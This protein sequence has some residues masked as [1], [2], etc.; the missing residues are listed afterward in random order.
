MATEQDT[1]VGDEWIVP[2]QEY[3]KF[4]IHK[5]GI[6]RI[7]FSSLI[8][9]GIP[10][11][12][13]IGENIRIF[14]LGKEIPVYVST[15]AL[16]TSTDFIEF[17]GHK[18]RGELDR[19]LYLHPDEDMLN[20]NASCFTDT[21][22]YFLTFSTEFEPK[23]AVS[24]FDPELHPVNPYHL[25][26]KSLVFA[27]NQNDPYFALGGGGSVSYSSFQHSEGFARFNE[28]SSITYIFTPGASS[29]GPDPLLHVKFAG[30]NYGNHRYIVSVNDVTVDTAHV[31]DLDFID[32]VYSFP[33]SSLVYQNTFYGTRL[34]TQSRH[35]LV[36]L[37]ITYPHTPDYT[38]STLVRLQLQE[39]AQ[40]RSYAIKGLIENGNLPII[41]NYSGS[42]R[43]VVNSFEQ[44]TFYISNSFPNQSLDL[45]IGKS[46]SGIETI[47][48]LEKKV[49]N[50]ILN[51]NPSYIIISHPQLMD[52]GD[53]EEYAN[54]RRSNEG[55]SY[56]VS[57]FS[58]DDL[59]DRFCYGIK[60]H[61]L[62][63]RNL[64]TYAE[65][66][67]SNT[68]MF[69]II[70]RGIEYHRSR[71]ADG[72]WEK[73]FF[74][75][76][77]GRPG[78]D[79]MLMST[80][81]DIM[82]RYPIGRL[83]VIN[84]A[85]IQE[86]LFKVKEHE[87]LST[88]QTL[89]SSR[90]LKNIMHIGGGQDVNEQEGFKTYLQNLG[91]ILESSSFGGN[92]HFFQKQST[93]NVEQS[94]STEILNLL[95]EGCSLINYFGH[96]GTTTFEYNI[97]D[98]SQWN[99]HGRYSIVSA[100]GCSAGQIYGPA[101]SL[102]D[103]YVH[104]PKEGAI[105]FIS[106]SGNQFSP[107][108][109]TWAK[110]WYQYIGGEG[111]NRSLGEGIQAGL[112]GLLP[113]INIS[114]TNLNQYRFL[115]EQQVLQG[116]PAI[117]LHVAQGPDY[118]PH[119][120]AVTIDEQIINSDLD[121]IDIQ[122]S[123]YNIGRNENDFVPFY[124]SIASA[125]GVDRIV[126]E[127]SV[128]VIGFEKQVKVKVPFLLSENTASF[129]LHIVL[130]PADRIDELPDPAAENNNHLTDDAGVSGLTFFVADNI[131]F[132]VYP[133]TDE[134]VNDPSPLLTASGP[135]ALQGIG[136]YVMEIDTTDLFNSPAFQR[137]SLNTENSS[138]INSI[139]Y[140]WEDDQ[141]YYWRVSPDSI[142]PDKGYKWDRRNFT[143]APGLPGGFDQQRFSQF[144]S[145]SLF[146]LVPNVVSSRFEFA[147]QIRN[148]SILNRYLNITENL[149]PQYVEE[150]TIRNEFFA[151]F[152][153]QKV[154]LFAVVFDSLSG[155]YLM[156]PPGG[157]YGS[158]NH[159]SYEIPCFP[160]R[161]DSALY[162]Q[163]LISFLEDSLPDDSKVLLYCYQRT[164]HPDYFPE[165]WAGD[166]ITFGKDLFTTLESVATGTNI[167]KTE[168]SGSVPF[169]LFYSNNS[170]LIE[171]QIAED[172]TEVL[173]MILNINRP[174]H[175]GEIHSPVIGPALEWGHILHQLSRPSQDDFVQ[176]EAYSYDFTDTLLV[177]S[178]LTTQDTSITDLDASLY[179]YLKLIFKTTDSITYQ[180]SQLSLLRVTFKDK[181]SEYVVV[182]PYQF[183][184]DTIFQGDSLLLKLDL[185]NVG[186]QTSDSIQTDLRII[187]ASNLAVASDQIKTFG[188]S[189]PN[190]FK[191]STADMEG[192]YKLLL[193]I[194]SDNNAIETDA[195]NNTGFRTFTV[196]GD[197]IN[198]LLD[199]TFD[200]YR[201]K[202]GDLVSYEP[203]ILITLLDENPRRRLSDT[204]TFEISLEYPTD[205][206]PRRIYFSD[207]RLTFSGAPLSGPNRATATLQ[208]TLN[209]DGFYTLF[210]Q[211][212]DASGNSAGDIEYRV[213]FR[214][215]LDES[216]SELFA[217]PNPF[218]HTTRFSYTLTGKGNPSTYFIEVVNLAGQFVDL[219][220]MNEIGE[221]AAGTHT[222]R[223]EWDG[224]NYNGSPLPSGMYLYR[225]V[226]KDSEGNLYPEAD[227]P[228]NAVS[229]RKG[230]N[231]IVIIR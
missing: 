156:N 223:Y 219:I 144:A 114:T 186:E 31:K 116:D 154:H 140:P 29:V 98:P 118:L 188:I 64:A 43:F 119:R 136:N 181:S 134:I 189:L 115:L 203:V 4:S 117:H 72:T 96:S 164:P 99:N 161:S 50:R 5:D 176:V 150:G 125:D 135:N 54:Y 79:A 208:P 128:E 60:K 40:P 9:N 227:L 85:G 106:S 82:P 93:E 217:F 187:S 213:R 113:N 65:R 147:H 163:Q 127:D 22:T 94:Q 200:G 15:D 49:F 61:P 28:N 141:V 153:D 137:I 209:E 26:K 35:T 21:S 226:V 158:F 89:E 100:M 20:P 11:G 201:I 143:Y 87:S 148:I 81:W 18:N 202:D 207:P 90:W 155:N 111:Y 168:I 139:N 112:R 126:L 7:P 184:S 41:Y 175:S 162:R 30:S 149:R 104:T 88:V 180:P 172:T 38:D 27:I 224:S 83:A 108:L 190:E 80:P 91:E 124:I 193:T 225:L 132:A 78:S 58:I 71:N 146:N 53:V 130:D 1:L 205:F 174:V 14:N 42:L 47:L 46:E 33:L 194:N 39:S 167:R 215:E 8:E 95:T 92:V 222:L 129:R 75:P 17:V 102:S 206:S 182:S 70:G 170:G 76:T 52:G 197:D 183:E 13:L 103:I 62:A 12:S 32:T 196:V 216:V 133:G 159:L 120:S 212:K 195:R 45:L 23:R 37:G 105:A 230:W 177:S 214:I 185:Q 55:G 151:T 6:Y 84:T 131:I 77:F 67:W 57:V 173:S 152:R 56:D 220:P 178:F 51:D 166:Q 16:F 44:D 73:Q 3:Y 218:R 19:Y 221:L 171:E 228:P 192:D 10:A 179:P 142:S 24:V 86:Y 97:Q 231:K 74:V 165:S 34:G 48:K 2:E 101:N 169:I 210:V 63:I 211:A 69:F 229:S 122:F 110:A 123:I 191:V 107:A 198:P 36:E 68:E 199:V 145:N 59:Y 204:S 138:Q 25:Y 157:K 66:N 160:F 109:N 121:S